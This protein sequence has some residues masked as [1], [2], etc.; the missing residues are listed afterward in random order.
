MMSYLIFLLVLFYK[1]EWTKFIVW[2][3]LE[4]NTT[5]DDCAC[6]MVGRHVW[7]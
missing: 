5:Q 4:D 1:F 2:Q 3:Q 7:S 6:E